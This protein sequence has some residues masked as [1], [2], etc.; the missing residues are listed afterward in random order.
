MF[1]LHVIDLM[2]GL[3][4]CSHAFEGEGYEVVFAI[5]NDI[6]NV[7]LYN[8]LC[9]SSVCTLGNLEDINPMDLPEAEVVLAKLA[10]QNYSSFFKGMDILEEMNEAVYGII[11]KKKPQYFVLKSAV[12]M[13]IGKNKVYVDSLLY[14]YIDMG[15]DVSYKVFNECEY[16]GFPV[17]GRQ[18]FFVGVREDK[19]AQPF[20]F[21]DSVYDEYR[22]CFLRE[23]AV[24][25]DSWYRK[26]HNARIMDK[27]GEFYW[28]KKGE[29]VSTKFVHMGYCRESYIADSVGLRRFTHNELASI[30]GLIGVDYN[31]CTNKYRMYSKISEELDY[32]VVKALARAIYK[33]SESGLVSGE[34][35]DNRK[36]VIQKTQKGMKAI[37]EKLQKVLYPKQ[38]IVNIHIEELKGLH[39]LD[40]HIE[41]NLVALMGTNGAGKSTILHALACAYTPY[42]NGDKYKFSFFF[43]PNPNASWK[44]SMFSITY[45]DE[46]EHRF[47]TRDYKKQIDRWAPRY[48]KRPVR[49]TFYFGISSCIPEIETEK[50]TSFI[51]Y[52]TEDDAGK[53]VEKIIR[54]AAYIL[55]KDYEGLT[56]HE[57]KRKKMLG[58]RTSS[59]LIYSSLS[60]GAGEQRVIKILQKVYSMSQYSLILIDEIDIL[61]HVTA[62]KRLVIR[63]SEIAKEKRL[64]IIFTT[65]SVEMNE[66][67]E[68]VDIRYIDNSSKKTLVYN[69]I[70]ADMIYELS[71]RNKRVLNVYVEDKLAETIVR[72]VAQRL[73]MQGFINIAKFGAASNAFVVASSFILKN[74][75]Y[76]N[77]LVVIDGD[78]YREEED[79]KREIEKVLSGTEKDH[80]DKVMSAMSMIRDLQIPPDIA[81][82]KYIYDML[83]EMD[84]GHEVVRCARKLKA[85]A[86]SHGWLDEIIKEIGQ[87]DVLLYQIMEIVSE[88][89]LWESYVQK[90]RDWLIE[91]RD[92]IGAGTSPHPLAE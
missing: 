16:S 41:K 42:S 33:N 26:I 91:K 21:P 32:F 75:D 38:R 59:Q 88:N 7:K 86:D 15:Y 85:V 84:D 66:M 8:E 44:N 71:E 46:N 2:C 9:K 77:V 60:M 37:S 10:N 39:K 25:V 79:K 27:E 72:C 65:H 4:A 30:K 22:N 64:Q 87:E 43:T 73:G 5:D 68:Y 28:R 6:E 78:V 17:N 45:F 83:V 80:D 63:L 20:L 92:I 82:E 23:E 89:P 61:L 69:K 74:E 11:E 3:G 53:Y 56:V 76:G 52:K 34:N 12:S 81:P 57:T 62:L 55:N 24:N 18:L 90:I 51:E 49:D 58:V 29:L 54:D 31:R 47:I 36:Q 13:L 50:Q 40:I 1:K 70:N 35:I 67:S 48:E 19:K 14:R